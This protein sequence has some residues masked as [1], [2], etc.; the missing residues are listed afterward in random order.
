MSGLFNAPPWFLGKALQAPGQTYITS[1]RH[2]LLFPIM[3]RA[4]WTHE[5][6]LKEGPVRCGRHR[7]GPIRES[8]HKLALLPYK[9]LRSLELA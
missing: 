6:F 9:G 8:E 5:G 2:S 3:V 7:E 1:S 4:D